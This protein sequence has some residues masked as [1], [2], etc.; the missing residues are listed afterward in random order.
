MTWYQMGGIV[1]GVTVFVVL[2]VYGLMLMWDDL[3]KRK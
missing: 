3:T 2:W 1:I